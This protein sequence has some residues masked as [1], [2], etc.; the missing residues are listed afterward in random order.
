MQ[1]TGVYERR[2]QFGAYTLIKALNAM[3]DRMSSDD[4]GWFIAG[5]IDEKLEAPGRMQAPPEDAAE[6]GFGGIC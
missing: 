1:I 2:L 6:S 4:M 3:V 5:R